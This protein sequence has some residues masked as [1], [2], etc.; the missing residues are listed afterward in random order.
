MLISSTNYKA[1]AHNSH[2][3]Y[4]DVITT[5]SKHMV[6]KSDAVPCMVADHEL[7]TST[8]NKFIRKK[9][10]PMYKTL[11]SFKNYTDNVLCDLL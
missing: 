7:T 5:N 1:Y 3:I 9:K 8:F 2:L 4:F 6:L 10:K 11:R